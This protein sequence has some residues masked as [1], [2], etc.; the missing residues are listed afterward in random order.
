LPKAL[1]HAT[2]NSQPTTPNPQHPTNNTHLATYNYEK[3]FPSA[4][5]KGSTASSIPSAYNLIF[6][7]K[8][9]DLLT[10][11]KNKYNDIMHFRLFL[12]FIYKCGKMP[13]SGIGL[14]FQ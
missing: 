7:W 2:P 3:Y 4:Y 6:I 8:E 13:T 9:H 10:I 12:M 1:Q 5:G 14:A 11:D